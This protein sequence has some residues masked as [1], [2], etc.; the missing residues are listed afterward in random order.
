MP[1]QPMDVPAVLDGLNRV[2]ELQYRSVIQY[3]VV[4]G[5]VFGLE[6]QYLTDR[7]F[8]FAEEELAD[9]RRIVEKI[10]ALGGEPSIKIEQPQLLPDVREASEWLVKSET[11]IVE[12]MKTIIPS[13]GQEGRSE[14]MEHLLE[15]LM[16]RKQEQIDFLIRATR[17]P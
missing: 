1:D 12:L 4:S 14:A 17:Q 9:T 10:N 11:E 2:L 7:L 5:S 16:L 8:S 13:T 3:T 6:H 15:H